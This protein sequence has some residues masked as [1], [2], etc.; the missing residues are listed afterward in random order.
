[1]LAWRRSSVSVVGALSVIALPLAG[2]VGGTPRTGGSSRRDARPR[3]PARSPKLSRRGPGDPRRPRRSL[4]RRT[5]GRRV[6]ISNTP[7]RLATDGI[8]RLEV[9]A[10]S[11][12]RAQ[13]RGAP[14][15]AGQIRDRRQPVS[16]VR[17]RLPDSWTTP[18]VPADHHRRAD[19]VH[20]H[21]ADD[22]R[23]GRPPVRRGTTAAT[24]PS[25]ATSAT[26]CGSARTKCASSTANS[27]A[28]LVT[29]LEVS[30]TLVAALLIAWVCSALHRIPRT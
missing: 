28:I 18:G 29:A 22:Y 8:A 3:S 10:P 5:P 9:L 19:P 21:G 14:H 11:T 13:L 17:S 16:I 2:Q 4:L 7:R 20:I 12:Q 15:P 1:M 24:L 30:T 23:R 6:A 26:I 27:Q 25:R